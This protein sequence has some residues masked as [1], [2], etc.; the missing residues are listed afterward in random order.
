MESKKNLVLVGMMGSGKSTIGS[1][2]SKKL[3][4]QFIDI[5]KKIEESEREKIT[6]IFE[7]KGESYFRKLEEKITT[8]ILASKNQVVSLGG[9]GFI[10]KNIRYLVLKSNIS[11]WLNWKNITLINRISKNNKRPL[12]FKHSKEELRDIILE[13]SKIYNKA[14]YKI[15]CQ[16][17]NKNE[18]VDR[19]INI[20]EKI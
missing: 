6:T 16:N 3:Q 9:G 11:F 13:R 4:F 5:H 17:L 15:N 7:K 20:Y 14:N 19:I 1:I 18:I 2:L 10:N 8:N 12:A